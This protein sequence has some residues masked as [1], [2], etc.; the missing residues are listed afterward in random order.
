VPVHFYVAA[1]AAAAVAVARVLLLLPELPVAFA[2]A[3]AVAAAAVAGCWLMLLLLLLLVLLLLLL[4]LS[5][6]LSKLLPSSCSSSWQ[7]CV[8]RR[9]MV[10]FLLLLLWFSVAAEKSPNFKFK[11]RSKKISCW[12]AQNFK[13]RET[14]KDGATAWVA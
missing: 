9:E 4:L 6:L 8:L 1:A 3:V 10:L 11:K 2:V 14:Y 13:K 7:P 5:P 12:R